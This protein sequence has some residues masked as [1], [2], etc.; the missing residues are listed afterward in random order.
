MVGDHLRS[1]HP[2][3]W[4]RREWEGTVTRWNIF[5]LAESSPQESSQSLLF[6]RYNSTTYH[7]ISCWQPFCEETG[8]C[9]GEWGRL[10]PSGDE[11]KVSFISFMALQS[12][13]FVLILTL[14]LTMLSGLMNNCSWLQ[15]WFVAPSSSTGHTEWTKEE[16][17]E[18]GTG[19]AFRFLFLL[20]KS[21][22]LF[23]FFFFWS[24]L[25]ESLL[26]QQVWLLSANDSDASTVRQGVHSF[27][28]GFPP[29]TRHQTT[30]KGQDRTRQDMTILQICGSPSISSNRHGLGKPPLTKIDEFWEQI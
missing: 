9:H 24:N 3:S 23:L 19:R 2:Q 5:Y 1:S 26:L 14:S 15:H 21:F 4:S 11:D 12:E 16:L 30:R 17:A 18:E 29:H 27:Q 10:F 13:L 25:C 6:Q 22:F 8:L 28:S 7:C 20:I